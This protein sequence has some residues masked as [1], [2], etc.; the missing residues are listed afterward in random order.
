MKADAACAPLDIRT[1]TSPFPKTNTCGAQ[2]IDLDAVTVEDPMFVIEVLS[3]STEATDRRE[4]LLVYR[5]LPSLSEYVLI[6]QDEPASKSI[7]GAAT[8]D[9]RRSSTRARKLSSSGRSVSRSA[10]PTS[11]KAFRSRR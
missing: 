4:K 9:G 8:V 10:W 6:S 3:P 2:T 11:T 7:A 1:N 5:T